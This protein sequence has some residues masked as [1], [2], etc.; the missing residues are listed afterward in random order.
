[1]YCTPSYFNYQSKDLAKSL[2]YFAE[3]GRITRDDVEGI[4]YLKVY[5]V[6]CYGIRGLDKKIT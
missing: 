3:P 2:I 1:M 4:E 6:N 5:S